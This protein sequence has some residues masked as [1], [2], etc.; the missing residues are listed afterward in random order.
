MLSARFA[1]FLHS[2]GVVDAAAGAAAAG[3]VLPRHHD[4]HA[5]DN[6]ITHVPPKDHPVAYANGAAASRHPLISNLTNPSSQETSFQPATVAIS[7]SNGQ[8]HSVREH[9]MSDVYYGHDTEFRVKD[10]AQSATE[11]YPGSKTRDHSQ[12]QYG[13]PGPAGSHPKENKS[14]HAGQSMRMQGRLQQNS[15]APVGSSTS[16]PFVNKVEASAPMR[17]TSMH[18]IP[19]GSMSTGAENFLNSG[20]RTAPGSTQTAYFGANNKRPRASSANTHPALLLTARGPYAHYPDIAPPAVRDGFV[21]AYPIEFAAA[22]YESNLE[23][24][25]A[26]MLSGMAN[27]SQADCTSGDVRIFS[28]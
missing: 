15:T 19:H 16:L 26:L 24:N 18:E 10:H 20:K 7:S 2:H 28:A 8:C 27:L 9:K 12:H 4:S 23:H 14:S 21:S 17:R 3:T 5:P 13:F 22:T 6:S 11:P 1:G 25:S